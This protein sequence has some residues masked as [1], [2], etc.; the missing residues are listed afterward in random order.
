MELCCKASRTRYEKIREAVI[1]YLWEAEAAD[2]QALDDL[3]YTSLFLKAMEGFERRFILFGPLCLVDHSCTS[4]ITYGSRIGASVNLIRVFG[5]DVQ[6]GAAKRGPDQCYVFRMKAPPR[7]DQEGGAKALEAFWR[8]TPRRY[9][10]DQEILM[11][12]GDSRRFPCCC[13]RC[14]GGARK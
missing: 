6:G 3:G 9:R 8:T 5:A 14:N 7:I 13:V 2:F 12:Y 10:K 4:R 1:G 11:H